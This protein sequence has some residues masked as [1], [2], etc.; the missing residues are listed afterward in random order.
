MDEDIT[1]YLRNHAG[2]LINDIVSNIVYENKYRYDCKD[3]T[4][5]KNSS[6]FNNSPPFKPMSNDMQKF[7][8]TV[9][10]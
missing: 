6:V 9:Y 8:K 10:S 2:T 4:I 3:N 7:I 1:S 5:S